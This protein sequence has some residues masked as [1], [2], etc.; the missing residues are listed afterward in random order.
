MTAFITFNRQHKRDG[1]VASVCILCQQTIATERNLIELVPAEIAHRCD[2]AQATP[3]EYQE[4]RH[5]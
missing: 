2:A 3:R 1:M 4:M 5:A